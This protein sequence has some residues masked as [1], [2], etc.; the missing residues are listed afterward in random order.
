MTNGFILALP[1]ESL[2]ISATYIAHTLIFFEIARRLPGHS[3]ISFLAR[4]TLITVIIHMPII[5]GTAQ[6]FFG[7]FPPEMELVAR[8]TYITLL[9]VV[10][11]F[12]SE[13]ISRI[14]DLKYF[15]NKSWELVSKYLP[16]PKSS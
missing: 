10:L 5:F 1:V 2:L 8:I 11:A 12:V 9:Y 14:V 6:F 15:T 16:I 3:I 4:A 13:F 7:L